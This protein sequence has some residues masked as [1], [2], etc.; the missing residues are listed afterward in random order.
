[1]L[2]E[3]VVLFAGINKL[4]DDIAA[5]VDSVTK[6]DSCS[7]HRA[8][9]DHLID[10]ARLQKAA[11]GIRTVNRVEPDDLAAV[12]DIN[13]HGV[14]GA[15]WVDRLIRASAE[16]EALR[17]VVSPDDVALVVDAV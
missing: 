3:P 14:V 10:I 15:G 4:S 16:Q 1:M 6:G 2:K 11:A 9:V 12:V 13:G 17:I 5:V 7:T 8:G